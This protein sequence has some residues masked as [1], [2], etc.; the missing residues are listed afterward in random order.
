MVLEDIGCRPYQIDRMLTQLRQGGKLDEV[1]GFVF[2]EMP[3]CS[4]NEAQGY[5]LQEVIVEVLGDLGVPILYGFPTGH[6]AR[7]NV[8][9]PFGV[10]GRL[11][12]AG[13]APR[14][15]LLEPAVTMR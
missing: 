13:D 4:Q 10:R 11:E 15:E 5:T 14:F 1:A 6:S 8:V 2:G 9:V 7:P 12:T 3:D